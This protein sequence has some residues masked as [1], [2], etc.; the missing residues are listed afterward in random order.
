L[1]HY[2]EHAILLRMRLL[3]TGLLTALT[4]REEASNPR[5]GHQLREALR[6]WRKE[7]KEALWHNTAE[8][9]RQYRS[10]DHVGN[11]RVVF[12]ICGNKYRLVVQFNYGVPVARIR[13]VGTHKEYDAIDDIKNV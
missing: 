11:N 12:N 3:G 6:A 13:F 7:V 1:F 4:A 5:Q 10:A 9:Q 2:L 8:I